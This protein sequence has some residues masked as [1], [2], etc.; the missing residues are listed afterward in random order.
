MQ[1]R[2]LLLFSLCVT[3]LC[4]SS[5]QED[6]EVFG[7]NEKIPFSLVG[8]VYY[9]PKRTNRLPDFFDIR[10]S[11]GKVYT[12]KLEIKQTSFLTGFPGIT[13]RYEWFA[14]DYHGF[15]AIDSAQTYEFALFS[16]DGSKLFIDNQLVV[17]NDGLHSAMV[18]RGNI[19][20]TEG[21]HRMNVQYFQG[22]RDQIALTL[23]YST[24]KSKYLNVF[25]FNYFKPIKLIQ[26]EEPTNK[27]VI[28]LEIANSILFS[29]D[30]YALKDV[31]KLVLDEIVDF[32]L[33]NNQEKSLIIEGYTDNKGSDQ[34][35]LDLSVNRANAVKNYIAKSTGLKNRI[36]IKGYGESKPKNDNATEK[37]RAENRRVELI[38]LDATKVDAYLNEK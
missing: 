35:N 38:I 16:D 19:F 29:Y 28:S 5:G 18:R 30:A 14:I 6:M 17:N 3:F 13:D 9:L 2:F 24:E 31:A 37:N 7:T 10:N 36:L 25:N 8:Y 22:P 11:V 26:K 21:I 4:M 23:Y 12:N 15:F 32:Y 1:I 33:I 34:Y 20:L 27:D